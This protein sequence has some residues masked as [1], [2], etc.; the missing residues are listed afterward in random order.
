MAHL[1]EQFDAIG[2]WREV[3][4][5]FA[6]IDPAGTMPDGSK[7]G[8]LA[9]FRRAVTGNSGPFLRTFT[10][11]LVIYA[12]GR[13]FEPY[14]APAVRQVLRGAGPGGYKFTDLVVGIVKSAPFQMRRAPDAPAAVAASR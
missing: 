12:L 9:D 8:S 3:D 10:E 13:P 2:R 14:D 5:S 1:L 6:R 11:K 4:R 7:F